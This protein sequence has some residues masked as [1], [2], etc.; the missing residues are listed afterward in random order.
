MTQESINQISCSQPEAS[1]P[2][3]CDLLHCGTSFCSQG[4]KP[5][6]IESE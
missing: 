3:V 5:C 4:E 2:G 1:G 6:R